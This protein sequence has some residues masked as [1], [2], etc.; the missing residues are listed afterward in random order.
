MAKAF[1]HGNWVEL[2]EKG[3]PLCDISQLICPKCKQPPAYIDGLG[4]VDA[5]IAKK[6]DG[7]QSICCGH[8]VH[9]A[10]VVFDDGTRVPDYHWERRDI[11]KIQLKAFINRIKSCLRLR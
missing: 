11:F 2:D 3:E 10:Y 8:G 5:C 9:T 7:V 6:I 4:Y 1:T